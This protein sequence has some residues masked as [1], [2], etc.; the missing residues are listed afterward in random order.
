[1]SVHFI[2]SI[3][4]LL[5]VVEAMSKSTWC[6]NG[7]FGS[8]T[9]FISV[10]CHTSGTRR[11]TRG[12]LTSGEG[13]Y[14]QNAY[15]RR[16]NRGPSFF[17]IRHNFTIGGLYELPVGKG[18]KVE[19]GGNKIA[20]LILGGAE[21][22][23][24][25]DFRAA[26]KDADEHDVGDADGADEEG[27][28]A[29]AEEEA[30]ERALGGRAGRQDGGGLADGDLV[31]S[32]GVCG[33]GEDGLDGRGV[34]GDAQPRRRGIAA[35][36]QLAAAQDPRLCPGRADAAGGREEEDLA[37]A[38]LRPACKAGVARVPARR[39]DLPLFHA[40]SVVPHCG[41]RLPSDHRY[42]TAK[43]GTNDS[44]VRISQSRISTS[45]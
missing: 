10:S 22:A 38:R 30:V 27:D 17:D 44:I 33:S 1:M 3:T 43:V 23:A 42:A 13:A 11:S 40:R 15:D 16:G 19:F 26:F 39:D 7:I 8:R 12:G 25:A 20:D 24:E 21:G 36:R 29:E 45:I 9:R 5:A 34:A 2:K 28:G 32:F 6:F 35:A 31:G 41:P 14:W 37:R 4:E 18:H